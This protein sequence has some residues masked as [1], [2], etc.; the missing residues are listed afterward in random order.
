MVLKIVQFA[1]SFL[2]YRAVSYVQNVLVYRCIEMKK[3]FA[4]IGPYYNNVE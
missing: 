1:A 3:F 4:E 2:P